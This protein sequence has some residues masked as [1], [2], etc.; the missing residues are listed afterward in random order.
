MLLLRWTRSRKFSIPWARR[1]STSTR[2]WKICRLTRL[3]H[4]PTFAFAPLSTAFGWATVLCIPIFWFQAFA[5]LAL[6]FD[7][8]TSQPDWPIYKPEHSVLDRVKRMDKQGQLLLMSMLRSF[9]WKKTEELNHTQLWALLHACVARAQMHHRQHAL[10]ISRLWPEET[11]GLCDCIAASIFQQSAGLYPRYGFQ[12]FK[13]M[14]HVS[15]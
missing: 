11:H 14:S 2:D 7:V 15:S 8:I 13:K 4:R 12:R 9:L 6:N 5:N 3:L 10:A 1:P